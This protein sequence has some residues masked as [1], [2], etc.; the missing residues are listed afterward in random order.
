MLACDL[1]ACNN[2][3]THPISPLLLRPIQCQGTYPGEDLQ[4]DFTQMPPRSG[5]KYLLV[6][7]DIFM[8]WPEAFPTRSE[9]AMDICRSLLK[10][11]IPRFGLPK[12]LQSDN[13]PSFVAKITQ[14]LMTALRIDYKPH[15]SW[16]SQSSWKVEKINDTLKKTLAKL[17]QE[18]HE[19]W[20]NLLPTALLRV[21]VF[22]RGGVRLSPFE[23]SYGRP[24]LTTDVPLDE[25][26]NRTLRYIINLGQV[27]KA[28]QDYVHKA[29]PAPTKNTEEAAVPSQIS[30]GDQVF[31]KTWK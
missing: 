25:E 5:Y 23:M 15:T 31:L 28:I 6:F 26:V 1:C 9:K 19:P 27:Q 4:L 30:P 11:I 14:G 10:E 13:G 7:V 12:S 22:P 29:L 2:P 24:F 16:H 8:G 21:C 18:M 3:Q 17:Y 20:T